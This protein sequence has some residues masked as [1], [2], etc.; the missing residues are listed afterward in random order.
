M[1]LK[2]QVKNSGILHIREAYLEELASSMGESE[3][4]KVLVAQSCPT[5]CS[6]MDSSPPGSSV[7]GSLQ[8]RILEWVAMPPPGDPADLGITPRSPTLQADS[9]LSEPSGV[10]EGEWVNSYHV[11]IV[12]STHRDHRPLCTQTQSGNSGVETTA[13]S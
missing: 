6:P 11:E 13:K 2:G 8:A 3:K 4:V 5:L 9:F 1:S 12:S 10:G 7:L